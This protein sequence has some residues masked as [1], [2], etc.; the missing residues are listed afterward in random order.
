MKHSA[1]R[2]QISLIYRT[3]FLVG[4]GLAFQ[5]VDGLVS[6]HPP[7]MGA[8]QLLEMEFPQRSRQTNMTFFSCV[9]LTNVTTVEEFP[10]ALQE[11][12]KEES[13]R[14]KVA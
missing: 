8:S 13:D 7:S 4:A 5:G 3:G 6:V 11:A 1:A 9:L 2:I 12:W 14:Q 10:R